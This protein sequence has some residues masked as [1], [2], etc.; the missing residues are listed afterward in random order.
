[1]FEVFEVFKNRPQLIMDNLFALI[2]IF[3][4]GAAVLIGWFL[5]GWLSKRTKR[6]ITTSFANTY[7]FFGVG[8]IV[9]LAYSNSFQATRSSFAGLPGLHELQHAELGILLYMPLYIIYVSVG[10]LSDACA[11]VFNLVT[12][13][14]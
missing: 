10:L 1:M 9:Y 6:Y 8:T 14:V 5:G 12:N 11:G 13:I 7:L 3:L 2:S 4:F